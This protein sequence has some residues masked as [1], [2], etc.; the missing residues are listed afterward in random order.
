MRVGVSGAH[1]TGKTTL[2]EEL[3]ARLAGHVPVNEPY[4]LLE[5]EGYEFEFPPSLDDYRA[6][7]RRSFRV[8][9]SAAPRVVFDRTPL[10][11]LA[12]LA[13]LGASV[14]SEADP[15]AVR[16]ALASLDLL[17]I[18]PVTAET[19]RVLPRP[20]MPRLRETVNDALLDLLS[21]DPLEAWG[22]VP[23]I[24]LNGP[25]EGR[26]EAVLAVLP[27]HLTDSAVDQDDF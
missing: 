3:C 7:L 22:D 10:D 8:L 4:F 13:A 2:V 11:F 12:Y 17:I 6:Q 27:A 16:S 26:L 5:E 9:R 21:S 1:G 24:E 18:T 14:E 20:D 19:E 23:V 25:L 15:P